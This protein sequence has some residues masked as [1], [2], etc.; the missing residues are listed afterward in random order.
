MVC[1]RFSIVLSAE[2][3]PASSRSSKGNCGF[4]QGGSR[5]KQPND[6][7]QGD[8]DRFGPLEDLREIMFDYWVRWWPF[9]ATLDVDEDNR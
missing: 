4:Y 9:Y 7:S 3:L 8:G 1:D 5:K 2:F 6:L